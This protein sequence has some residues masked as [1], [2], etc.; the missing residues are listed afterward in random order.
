MHSL[1]LYKVIACNNLSYTIV[2]NFIIQFPV[3][4]HLS[5]VV[6]KQARGLCPVLQGV[7]IIFDWAYII[8]IVNFC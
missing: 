7:L 3:D 2:I 1:P 8:V 4:V 6:L 5:N